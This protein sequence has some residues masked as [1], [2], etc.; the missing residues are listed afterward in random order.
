MLAGIDTR[1]Y[2]TCLSPRQKGACWACRCRP[3]GVF[4]TAPPLQCPLH[5]QVTCIRRLVCIETRAYAHA[6]CWHTATSPDADD[7]RPLQPGKILPSN[8]VEV[9]HNIVVGFYLPRVEA[10]LGDLKVGRVPDGTPIVSAKQKKKEGGGGSAHMQPP[11]APQLASSLRHPEKKA[12]KIGRGAHLPQAACSWR[13]LAAPGGSW[14]LLAAPGSY[15]VQLVGVGITALVVHVSRGYLG[16]RQPL[17]G[18]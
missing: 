5:R 16:G 2:G 3:H 13:P 9:L 6:G 7:L 11:W 18:V 15:Q 12:K 4:T 8:Q 10:A 14:R 17:V 1:V